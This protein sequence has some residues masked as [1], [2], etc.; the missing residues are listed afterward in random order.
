VRVAGDVEQPGGERD[1]LA[2]HAGREA[3]AVPALERVPQAALHVRAESEPLGEPHRDLAVRGEVLPRASRARGE[4]LGQRAQPQRQRRTGAGAR[5]QEPQHV[6][7]APG[8]EGRPG[9]PR[10]QVVA[11]AGGRL[12]GVRRAA[13]RVQQ[14]HV[15]HGRPLRRRGAAGVRQPAGDQAGHERVLER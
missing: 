6:E 1:R 2:G 12:V 4:R 7:A 11:G 5:R 15:V 13:D 9:G 14:R 10:G 8:I 3:A